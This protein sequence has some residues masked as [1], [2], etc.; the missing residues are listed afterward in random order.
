MVCEDWL[1]K[2]VARPLEGQ[3]HSRARIDVIRVFTSPTRSFANLMSF[4]K[5]WFRENRD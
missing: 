5:P 1:D 2:H 3:S 4:H